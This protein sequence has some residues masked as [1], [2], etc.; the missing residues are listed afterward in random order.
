MGPRAVK[1]PTA[2]TTSRGKLDKGHWESGLGHNSVFLILPS[3]PFPATTKIFGL[4]SVVVVVVVVAVAVVVM[5]VVLL[6]TSIC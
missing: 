3:S 4:G 1:N 6:F 2:P 5:V